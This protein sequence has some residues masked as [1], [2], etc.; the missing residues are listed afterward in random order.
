MSHVAVRADQFYKL[1]I[2]QVESRSSSMHV[3][4]HI[5]HHLLQTSLALKGE[6][7]AASKWMEYIY[8]LWIAQSP[9]MAE[10][11]GAWFNGTSYFGMNMLTL[12]D[13][14]TI[15]KD[16]T[17]VDFMVSPWFKNNPRWLMYAFPPV[18]SLTDFQMMAINILAL[19]LIM[20]DIQ[21]SCQRSSRIH[22]LPGIQRP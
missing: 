7:P 5:M 13:V 8:E 11:D 17:G 19:R 3:W 1:W 15:F 2:G 10:E 16:L 14:S 20:P 6:L 4:Q 12:V 22:T 18:P 9:K 21:M